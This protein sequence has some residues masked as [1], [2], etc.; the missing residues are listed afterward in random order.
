MKKLNL[1]NQKFGKLLVIGETEYVTR[2]KWLCK[3]DCG[4]TKIAATKELR[5]GNTK[6]CGCI[7]KQSSSIKS[8]FS[9]YL[10]FSS[11]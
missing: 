3:C 9:S 10:S 4:N 5:N 6:S 2:V 7:H 8:S 11:F 1:L